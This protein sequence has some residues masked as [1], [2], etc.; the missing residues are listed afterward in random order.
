MVE[1]GHHG[2]ATGSIVHYTSTAAESRT[3]VVSATRS[4]KKTPSRN[5]LRI[6]ATRRTV[7]SALCP[8]PAAV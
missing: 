5:V 7:P 4:K 6:A 3:R 1:N 8:A 2:N